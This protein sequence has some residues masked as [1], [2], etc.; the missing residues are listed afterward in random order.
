MLRHMTD[1]SNTFLR[2]ILTETKTIAIVGVSLNEMRPSY[3]VA[4]HLNLKGYR[5]IPVNP[6]QAGK[7]LF[8]EMIY[9]SLAD[10]P[11]EIGPIDMV[12]I[13][14]RSEDAGPIVNDALASLRCR[15]LRI[16]MDANRCDQRG[17]CQ[18]YKNR[19]A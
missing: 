9:A 19:R 15:G 14:R 11:S 13:F 2:N 17:R 5:I 6:G 1:Y 7:T 18:C 12:D 4:R 10:I 8:G 16:H 3:F